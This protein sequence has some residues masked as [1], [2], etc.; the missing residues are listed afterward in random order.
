[1]ANVR[2]NLNA[3]KHYSGDVKAGMM[4]RGTGSCDDCLYLVIRNNS[5]LKLIDVSTGYPLDDSD[6]EY[7]S[8]DTVQK[9]YSVVYLP[10][11]T[12]VVE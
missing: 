2:F 10:E 7:D 3:P 9:D 1:M 11:T 5:S 4:F 8:I 12:I 6:I